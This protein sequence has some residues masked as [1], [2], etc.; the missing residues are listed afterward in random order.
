[1]AEDLPRI[2]PVRWWAACIVLGIPLWLIR[3]N[4][5]DGI[6]HVPSE[7]AVLVVT[8]HLS[9]RDPPIAGMA[10]FPRRLFYFAKKELFANRFVGWFFSG[11]GAFPVERG[12][13]DR[14]AFRAARG[15]LK[16]GD[17]LLFFPEGTRSRNGQLGPPFPGAGSLGL[18]PE[19]T[20]LPIG[21][22]GS[23]KGMRSARAVIG[24]PISLDDIV[25]GSRS[26]RSR[27]A[28]ER[29]MHAIGELIVEAGG[30][31]Q[32]GSAHG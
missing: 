25:E 1:M 30:P 5:I 22:W 10:V 3:R 19:V 2:G 8:N 23:H 13:A 14:D 6:E 31:P 27:R 18:D 29:I 11:V 17:A 26:E 20:V 21:I 24:P 9:D 7:G 32:T 28:V 12:A 16:R 4:R 15:I